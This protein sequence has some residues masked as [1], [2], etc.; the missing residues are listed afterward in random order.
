MVTDTDPKAIISRLGTN[1]PVLGGVTLKGI[2]VFSSDQTYMRQL[3][4]YPDGTRLVETIVEADTLPPG[5]VIQ[6]DIIVGGVTFEDGTTTLRLTAADFDAL[7]QHK[8]RF[9]WPAGLK[10]SVCHTITIFQ[11]NTIIGTR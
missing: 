3:E 11:G 7:G 2:N 9:L 6:F 5:V 1:G 10:T 8:I 4:T